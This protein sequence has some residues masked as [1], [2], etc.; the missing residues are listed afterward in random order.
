[1][2]PTLVGSRA[3]DN[4]VNTKAGLSWPGQI[5]SGHGLLLYY[6]IVWPL[7]SECGASSAALG[8]IYCHN[9]FG[10]LKGVSAKLQSGS[11]LRGAVTV[12]ARHI[13]KQLVSLGLARLRQ[14]HGK[15]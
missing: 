12:P 2:Q 9:S 1:M 3:C 5:P 6:S 11:G 7:Q 13:L 10:I 15:A 8:S 4:V 14:T